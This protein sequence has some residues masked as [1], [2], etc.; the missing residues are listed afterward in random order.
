MRGEQNYYFNNLFQWKEVREK[1]ILNLRKNDVV[2]YNS[3]VVNSYNTIWCRAF[4]LSWYCSIQ[5]ILMWLAMDFYYW[6][7]I[8]SSSYHNISFGYTKI[9][10][11]HKLSLL[12]PFSLILYIKNIFVFF[13]AIQRYAWCFSVFRRCLYLLVV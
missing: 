13:K 3:I 9:T 8:S 10:N 12:S 1:K 11:I 4:L 2:S 6:G 5:V 7:F